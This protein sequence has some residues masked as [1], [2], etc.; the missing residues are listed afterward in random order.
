MNQERTESTHVDGVARIGGLDVAGD[1]GR[2]RG[3]SAAAARDGDL[4]AAD[5]ELRTSVGR[6]DVQGDLPPE[7][8]SAQALVSRWA[9]NPNRCVVETLPPSIQ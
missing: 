3:G 8:P 5:V 7:Y 4:G 2:R 6:G 1:L 9:P